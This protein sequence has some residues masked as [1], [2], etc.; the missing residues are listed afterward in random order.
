MRIL[1]R[2]EQLDRAC[3]IPSRRDWPFTAPRPWRW[4]CPRC[5]SFLSQGSCGPSGLFGLRQAVSAFQPGDQGRR[6][7]RC[8]ARLLSSTSA[9]GDT[10]MPSTL[11]RLRRDGNPPA[12]ARRIGRGSLPKP[13]R[14]R[15]WLVAFEFESLETNLQLK[16]GGI[17]QIRILAARKKRCWS[18]TFFSS[19]ALTCTTR[20]PDGWSVRNWSVLVR[21]HKM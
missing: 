18:L 14:V 7:F 20:E 13:R 5:V 11:R 3:D 12:L 19:N 17:W 4:P 9:A 6:W 21:S 8:P 1:T 2:N 15:H 10:R 16:R